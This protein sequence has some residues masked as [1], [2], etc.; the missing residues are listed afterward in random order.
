MTAAA[1]LNVCMHEQDGIMRE[2]ARSSV[3]AG[4]LWG[5][6]VVQEML[7]AIHPRPRR[8]NTPNTEPALALIQSHCA[9]V[10]VENV[11]NWAQAAAASLV[12]CH[13]KQCGAYAMPSS[14]WRG[15]QSGDDCQLLWWDIASRRPQGRG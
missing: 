8:W 13:N 2:G 10:Q 1:T 3:T 4:S 9:L 14:A 12:A 11:E 15:K 5:D 6:I 7:P